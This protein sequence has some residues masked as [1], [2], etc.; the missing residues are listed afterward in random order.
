[1]HGEFL[2]M[3]GTKMSKRFGNILTA[4]DL[5]EEHVDAATVRTLFATTHYR[6]KL[7]FTDEALAAAREG[8]RRLGEFS[9][10]FAA[11]AGAAS[12]AF[13]QIALVLKDEFGAAMDDDLNTPRALAALFEAAR[14]GNR[15]LDAGELPT[16]AF[17]A[18]WARASG[19][20][21][22]VPVRQI[23]H[24]E[25]G[26]PAIAGSN[27]ESVDSTDAIATEAWAQARADERAKAKGSRDFAEADRLR[28]LL[29]E[30]GWEVRDNRDGTATVQRRL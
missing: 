12:G 22:V 7:D 1:M 17:N 19:V 21:Q 25:P 27:A 18:A 23:L 5:R 3:A 10:R 13:D 24:A 26:H 20:L 11:N 16:A 6:Q 8:S 4:R 15:A 14:S 2:T 29:A 30:H 9:A 28:A